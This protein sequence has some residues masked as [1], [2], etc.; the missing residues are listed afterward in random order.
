[1]KVVVYLINCALFNS[2]FEYKSLNTKR[3][4][5]YKKFLHEVAR[6]SISDSQN[7]TEC[8]SGELEPAEK[9]P[10]PWGPNQGPPSRLSQLGK[11]RRSILQDGAK[12]VQ[13]EIQ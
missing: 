6:S 13:Q 1:M 2:F 10:T 12:F 9:E 5:K 11:A 8:S 4:T 7:P 3:K